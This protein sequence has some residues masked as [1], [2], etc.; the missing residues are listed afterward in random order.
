M[1]VNI[2]LD[3]NILIYAFENNEPKKQNIAL[4]IIESDLNNIILST[5]VINEFIN[6]MNK[7]KKIPFNKIELMV[8]GLT[9]F[10]TAQ[11]S[12]STIKLALQIAQKYSYSYFDSLML[13]SAIENDCPI[14]YSEDMHNN[15]EILNKLKIINPF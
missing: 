6:V 10:Q 1:S 7:K 11:I 12:N 9:Y 15:H 5:Q 3:S 2:F 13:S 4:N 8:D 14:I